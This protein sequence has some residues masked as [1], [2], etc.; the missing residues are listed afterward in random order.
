MKGTCPAAFPFRNLLCKVLRAAWNGTLKVAAFP[1]GGVNV[2][3]CD[4]PDPNAPPCLQPFRRARLGDAFAAGPPSLPG[5]PPFLSPC[6]PTAAWPW[7]GSRAA[8]A[9]GGGAVEHFGVTHADRAHALARARDAGA[10]GPGGLPP[11]PGPRWGSTG[12]VL[13]DEPLF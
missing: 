12:E 1:F 13:S 6:L 4:G 5:Q 10:S 3:D 9:R 8:A 7:D 11:R 2:V